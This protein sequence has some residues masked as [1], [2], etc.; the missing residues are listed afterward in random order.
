M[1]NARGES[2]EDKPMF[3]WSKSKEGSTG[4]KEESA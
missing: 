2:M 1:L 3:F 4:T